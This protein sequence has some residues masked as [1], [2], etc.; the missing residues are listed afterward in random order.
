M[1]FVKPNSK[2]PSVAFL[3]SVS[4]LLASSAVSTAKA[5]L[6]INPYPSKPAPRSS[7]KAQPID[8]TDHLLPTDVLDVFPP[9]EGE[10]RAPQS[11]SSAPVVNKKDMQPES[12]PAEPN[13]VI[14]SPRMKA[15]HAVDN[16]PQFVPPASERLLE[17]ELSA[18][19]KLVKEVSTFPVTAVREQNWNGFKGANL[20]ETL[21]AWSSKEGVELIW[22][23][24]DSDFDVRKT[25][26]IQ[27]SYEQAVQALL[28]QYDN[29]RIRPVGRLHLSNENSQR[30]L[31]VEVL[32]AP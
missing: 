23:S 32:G 28:E 24:Q 11:P 8:L 27:G 2:R 21:A 17:G 19:T 3:F 9:F 4:L 26:S 16:P 12:E 7:A 22:A 31:V 14:V 13:V 5:D 30:A 1:I 25:F 18:P 29:A 6:D 20:R 10:L 15:A